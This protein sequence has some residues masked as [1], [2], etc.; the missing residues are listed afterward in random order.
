MRTAMPNPR[1]GGRIAQRVRHRRHRHG[2]TARRQHHQSEYA[3][4]RSG[5]RGRRTAYSER[6][7]AAAVPAVATRLANEETRL[8]Y[9]YIDLRRDAM[10]FNIET[11]AQGAPRRSAI[12]F[13]RMAFSKSK[14]RS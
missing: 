3:H 8:K 12:I 6:I 14:R 7:Q 10:Q 2:Q 11:A 13:L 4:R 1:E 5:I 9:R